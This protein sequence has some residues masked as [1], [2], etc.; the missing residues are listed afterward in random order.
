MNAREMPSWQNRRKRDAGLAGA[1][2]LPLIAVVGTGASHCS[3]Y[4][5]CP[6]SDSSCFQLSCV[7][8]RGSPLVCCMEAVWCC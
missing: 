7:A 6:R 8:Q 2:H 3:L 5:E 4:G 1:A